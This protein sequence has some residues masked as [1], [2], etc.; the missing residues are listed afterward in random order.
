MNNVEIK[1]IKLHEDAVLPSKAHDTDTGYDLHCVTDT[2]IDPGT[3]NVVP[4]G[5]QVGHVTPGYWYLVLPKSGLGFK[6]HLQPHLGVID[7]SYR[8]SLDIKM[9]N[10]GKDSYTFKRGDKVAQIAFFP[11][12]APSLDWVDK[13]TDTDRGSNGFGSS[14]R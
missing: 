11:V 9:Y 13:A 12:I 7:Q 14:G 4:V 5:L 2:V 10:F 6:H 1:F 3:S 8:G